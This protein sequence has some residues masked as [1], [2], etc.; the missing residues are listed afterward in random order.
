[1]GGWMGGLVD[2]C[3][4]GWVDG[5]GRERGGGVGWRVAETRAS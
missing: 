1:M 2:G 5:W 3:V 4:G